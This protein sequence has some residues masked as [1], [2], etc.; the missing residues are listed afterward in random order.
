MRHHKGKSFIA[1]QKLFKAKRALYF[2]NLHGQTYSKDKSNKDTSPILAGKISIVCV[3]STK[4][5]ENQVNT[6]VKDEKSPPE[7]QRL[8][9][10][11]K[12]VLQ[13]VRINHVENTMQAWLV[14]LFMPGLRRQ[15]SAEEQAR[16]F[17]V[18]KGFTEEIREAIGVLNSKVGYTFLV[19]GECKIRWA[20]SADAQPEE[21][22]SLLRVVRRSI[23]EHR[24]KEDDTTEQGRI[25]EGPR[26][27]EPT[28]AVA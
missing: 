19:D 24:A 7:L 28:K 23:E 12:D 10:G 6:F 22:G 9:N 11:H 16:H 13:L 15:M 8:L 4:W 17:L 21:R 1:P 25:E 18:R 3:Y 27:E 14:K 2:P 20:G 26:R 5:A